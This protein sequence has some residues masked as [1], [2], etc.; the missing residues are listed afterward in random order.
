VEGNRKLDLK[1]K[2]WQKSKQF[3][4]VA[5]LILNW[6]GWKD[7]IECLE[8]VFRI[9]Y[10]NYQV[11]VIDNASTD[12]SMEK[13]KAW[14][15]GKQEVLTPEPTH[16]LY[17]L[18]HPPVKKP[19]L[20]IEYNRKEAE[21]GGN[22]EL[23][24]SLM[25]NSKTHLQANPNNSVNPTTKYPL[26]LIQT[27]AN[28]GFAGGNNV[29]IRYTLAKGDCDYVLLLNNDTVMDKNFLIKLVSI[30]EKDT[31]IGI[32]S[33]KIYYYDDPKRVE[34]AGAKIGWYRGMKTIPKYRN[35]LDIEISFGNYETQCPNGACM[36]IKKDVFQEIGI[37]NDAL[38][39]LGEEPEFAARASRAGFI[40]M[41]N[42][43]SKI[44]HK[45]GFS[46]GSQDSPS[47]WYYYHIRNRL[48]LHSLLYKSKLDNLFFFVIFIAV[49]VIRT[50]QFAI[51]GRYGLIRAIWLG[52]IDFVRGNM[53]KG[54]LDKLV[55]HRK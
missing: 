48:Y 35:K 31:K 46:R 47:A 2:V 26:I 14:A 25:I 17:H 20:Y 53:G 6:N 36:L 32:V 52:V 16:P 55:R 39:L 22:P 1:N 27:G 5:I 51:K 45:I 4:K 28:L 40:V 18:S 11:V 29:G 37:F 30:A 7:T 24:N 21:A 34:Y 9:S 44:W 19:I 13:I 23:E 12:G 49:R 10:P 54:S 33:P 41:V 50:F 8:S 3:S 15:E 43:D 42:F 38:F